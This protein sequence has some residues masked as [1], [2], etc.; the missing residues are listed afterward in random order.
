MTT[1]SEIEP[2]ALGGATAHRAWG[3]LGIFTATTFLSAFLLFLIQPMFAKMVLPLLGGAPSVWAVALLFF[4]G[5]LLVGY[6]YAHLLV[7]HVPAASTGFIHLALSAF[8]FLFLPIAIPAG[9]S[10]PPPG[11]AYLWQL[12][13]FAVA[14]GIPFATVAANAP[15]LQAWFSRAGHKASADPYFL[16]AASNLGSLIALLGYPFVFEPVFGL[17]TLAIVW[18]AG[19]AALVVALGLCF[20]RVR[21][22]AAEGENGADAAS[23]AATAAA[24]L[25]APAWN[26]RLGWVGLAFVPSALL[27]AFT[28]HIATDVA[29]APLV[30]VVP[31]AL[32]LLT[33]VIVFRER[34]LIPRSVLLTAHAVAVVLALLQLSQTEKET[35]FYAAGYGIAAFVASTLVAHRTL[36]EARPDARNLTEFYMWMS[37]GGVLGGIFAALLAP[38]IFS[39][40]FEYPLLLA[41]T[42]ACRPGAM[43][44]MS[45]S[46]VQWAG[47]A[48]LV[49][50]GWALIAWGPTLAFDYDLHF[51][52]WGTT[53]DIAA[54]FALVA[55]ALWYFP[56]HMLV[57][58]LGMYLT[59]V[60]LPSGVHRG[61]AQRSYFGVYRVIQSMDG[62]FNVLQHGTT[63]HGAQRIR[64]EEGKSVA[65]VTPAT[66][67]HP[68]SPMAS[69]IR[70]TSMINQHEGVKGKFGVIG[71]G[72]GSLAC[73]SAPGETWRFFEIDPVVVEIAKSR[74]FT[75]LSNCQPNAEVV[76]GDARLTFAREEID[77]YDLMIVDAFSSDAIPVHMMTAE[78]LTLYASKLKTRGVAVLHISNRYLDLEEVLA[79]T[80]PTLDV[81][82][83][84]LVIEDFVDDGY[85]KTGSTVVLIGK[86]KATIERFRHVEGSRDIVRPT[87]RPWTDDFSDIL[88]PFMAQ[89]R[90]Y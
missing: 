59:V 43:D 73:Y 85:V 10:E 76:L 75:F 81:E 2:I 15:L 16:Y 28:N 17:K 58:A 27:T 87:V 1:P 52:R 13:L 89:Y 69:A 18:T 72:A 14:I 54:I 6:G 24:S 36:Y 53:T 51:G 30:W 22:V 9:W 46:R 66:Y 71:L 42:F 56:P 45:R 33:F 4:Q 34:A 77:S 11:D 39:E 90:K 21:A 57:A 49:V 50:G 48:A 68:E 63:L 65:D 25:H 44:L 29:S 61:D 12:G 35:W 64:D 47:M 32:Y 84:A 23:P 19:F 80:L 55:L 62:E 31:L 7:R 40:V 79:A 70:L 60:L 82:L 83:H 86:D 41:L 67:Y 26:A 38:R 8:A 78:A 37:V 5:A 20:L 3:T 88:G 74:N